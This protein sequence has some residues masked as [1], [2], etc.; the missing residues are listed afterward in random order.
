MKIT[1][2][3]AWASVLGERCTQVKLVCILA[4]TLSLFRVPSVAADKVRNWQSGTLLEMEKQEEVQGATKTVNT[5]GTAKNKGNKTDYS[6]TTTSTTTEDRNVFQ[7]YTIKTD[8]KTYVVRERLLFPWS[9]PA[10]VTVGG[11]AKY[12]I[13]KNTMY[14]LDEDG[15]QH[16]AAVRKVSMNGE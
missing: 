2:Y 5:D 14:L 3:T 1:W 16:R 7:V 11:P 13:E 8:A 6:E 15:R 10:N 9:K 4:F 12:A